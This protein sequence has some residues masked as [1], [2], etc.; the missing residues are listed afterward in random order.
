MNPIKSV[1]L[2]VGGYTGKL[3]RSAANLPAS[4]T[5]H[6]ANRFDALAAYTDKRMRLGVE[7]FAAKNWNSVTSASSDTADGWS[8]FGSFAVTPKILAFG[9][10]VWVKP[11]KGMN[12]RLNNHYLNAGVDYK[13]L[14]PLDLAMVYKRER[15]NHGLISTSNGTIGGPLE[16]TYD[17]F[18]LFGQFSF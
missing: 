13:P 14:P 4:A 1:M 15:A 10:A 16:G 17:E 12:A 6:I 2:A 7:Y 11:R 9:R 8:A 5:P 3:G 18:G